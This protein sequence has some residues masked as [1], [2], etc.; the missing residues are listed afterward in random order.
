MK[1]VEMTKDLYDYDFGIKINLK[2]T[3]EDRQ[4]MTQQ[5]FTMQQN[6]Q[7][8]GADFFV[9]YNMISSGDL[10]KAQLYFAK[11]TAAHMKVI[12]Q[13][14][15]E[16]MQ[17]Q[18]QSNAQAAQVAEQA[19]Q[20]TLQMEMQLKAE[21]LQLENQLKMQENAQLHQFKMDEIRLTLT[22]NIESKAMEKTMDYALTNEQ[23]V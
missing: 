2:P 5:L 15:I 14:E 22:G 17:A 3:Q 8:S 19:A 13:M 12:Q 21:T 11:A 1:V 23:P 7:I 9:L 4:M 6:N 20:Q 10:K 18:A 16:K